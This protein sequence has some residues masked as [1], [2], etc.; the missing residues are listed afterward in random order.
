MLVSHPLFSPG[1]RQCAYP[2][3]HFQVHAPSVHVG[4]PFIVL[5]AA[6]Q[7]PQFRT[8]LAVPMQRPSQHV[9]PAPQ[10]TPLPVHT[11]THLPPG[12]HR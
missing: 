9:P 7:P 2:S 12:L 5:H 1:G 4:V 8:S 3:A 10:G 11:S 6:P